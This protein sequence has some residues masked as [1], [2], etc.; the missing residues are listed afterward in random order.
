MSRVQVHKIRSF[1]LSRVITASVTGVISGVAGGVVL[2]LSRVSNS[3][4][5]GRGANGLCACNPLIFL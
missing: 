2:I 3:A 4:G 5:L 1:V